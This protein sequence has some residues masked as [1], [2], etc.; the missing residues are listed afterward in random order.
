MLV[1]I[2]LQAGTFRALQR[3]VS[4]R[5]ARGHRAGRR[6]RLSPWIGVTN[7]ALAAERGAALLPAHIGAA[8]KAAVRPRDRGAP[9]RLRAAWHRNERGEDG[10]AER[11]PGAPC[12]FPFPAPAGVH[13]SVHVIRPLG[14]ENPHDVMA[15]RR[16]P[17]GDGRVETRDEIFVRILGARG[18]KRTHDQRDRKNNRS[19]AELLSRPCFGRG[20][21]ALTRVKDSP[22][23]G[24]FLPLRS[25]CSHMRDGEICVRVCST[26]LRT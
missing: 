15:Q 6:A 21:A 10:D 1:G 18:R 22:R 25:M 26:D 8:D 9:G 20:D 13:G 2:L 12:P 4:R 5:P 7:A 11:E 14:R 24:E 23:G 19:S 17:M 3:P 16:L